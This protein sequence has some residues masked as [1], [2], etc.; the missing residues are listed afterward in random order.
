M[1]ETVPITPDVLRWARESA[2]LTIGDVVKKLNRKGI[3][4]QVIE[5]WEAGF[6]SPTYSQL[7]RLAYDLYKRPL[8]G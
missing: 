4:S 5:E 7:E 6:S 8:A 3:T 1:T 2:G